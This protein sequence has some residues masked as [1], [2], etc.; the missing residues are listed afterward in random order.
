MQSKR[1]PPTIRSL[2]VADAK[3]RRGAIAVLVGLLTIVFLSSVVL[4]VDVAYMQLSRTR[5]RSATDAAARAAGEALS[6]AQDLDASRQAAKDIAQLNLV[7]GAPL[8]LDDSDI[9]FGNSTQEAGGAWSF[10]A[11]GEPINAV[12]VNG[13][14]TR[15]APSGSI[16]TLFGKVFA[17]FDFEPVQDATVVRLD[18]DIC[19]V[20]DR[21]SSMKL[22]LTDTA[23]TMS[24][25]DPRFCQPPDMSQSRWSALSLAFDRFVTALETT[26]QLEH[27]SLVSYGSSG[28][29]CSHGNQASSIDQALSENYSDATSAMGSLSGSKFNGAT[30]IEA[31]INSGISALTNETYARP[32][33]A[34]TMVL[35]TDGHYTQ[36]T[37]PS[38]VAPDAVGHDIVI[39]TVTFGDGADQDEMRAV[40]EATGGNFYHAPDAETL[41]DVFE[42][43]ALTLPVMFTD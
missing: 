17:V 35:M 10:V 33:A 30:N 21:S 5:L 41:Q 13:R 24:T 40:A 42:E 8:L 39:H 22:Y 38:L 11:G 31:G 43:I 27:L 19:I 18:R 26:P 29:W 25:G 20:V 37:A 23:P 3:T 6:R 1:T 12:R 28:T 14:R 16:P 36:G 4:S 15:S 34:K 7:A 2:F 32:F 9:V